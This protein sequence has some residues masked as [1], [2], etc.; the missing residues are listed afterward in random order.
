MS[1]IL[2]NEDEIFINSLSPSLCLVRKDQ[3]KSPNFAR[4]CFFSVSTWMLNLCQLASWILKLASSQWRFF[5]S[6]CSLF[7][8][9]KLFATVMIFQSFFAVGRLVRPSID[10]MA[11]WPA[12][13]FYS[14]HY[15]VKIV[16]CVCWVFN[17]VDYYFPIHRYCWYGF[18]FI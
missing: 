15:A 6:H 10:C 16:F 14:L 11:V 8:F 3:R 1:L 5:G 13:G 17:L 4:R 2:I 7:L 9:Q 18:H 12:D